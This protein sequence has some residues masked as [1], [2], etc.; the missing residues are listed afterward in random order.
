MQSSQIL[1]IN[2]LELQMEHI[3]KMALPNRRLPRLSDQAPCLRVRTS[4]QFRICTVKAPILATFKMG[5][6]LYTY[7]MIYNNRAL[8]Q[9]RVA[10]LP[11]L[12]IMEPTI[13]DRR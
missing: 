11:P 10:L 13:I 2:N 7:A 6:Y 12:Q 5:V 1:K 4:R 3:R 9:Y 8:A